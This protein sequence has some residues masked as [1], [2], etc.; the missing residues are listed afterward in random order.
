[1]AQATVKISASDSTLRWDPIDVLDN[2]HADHHRLCDEL[3]TIADGLPDEIDTSLCASMVR[4]LRLD[5]PV[6]HRD[7]EDVLFP[8]LAARALPE[9]GIADILQ[10]LN[11]E[12]AADESFATEL[13]DHLEVM[14]AGGRPDNPD[15]VGYMLR[16]FFEGYR[17][18]LVWEQSVILP[19]ARRRLSQEDMRELADR[20]IDRRLSGNREAEPRNCSG[21]CGACNPDKPNG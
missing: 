10:Q 8:M 12:H 13:L 2:E 7:E 20:M 14:A 19:L 5:V 3:E 15:M 4:A 21:D 9:D 11:F 1:M 6:H 17:R 18:H 16:G